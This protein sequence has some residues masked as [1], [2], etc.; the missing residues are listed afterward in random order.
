MAEETQSRMPPNEAEL[1]AGAG[2]EGA[3]GDAPVT[4]STPL[5]ASADG[6]DPVK[7]TGCLYQS[8]YVVLRHALLLQSQL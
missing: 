3:S 1:G 5:A 4:E 2:A 6:V 8:S 7:V